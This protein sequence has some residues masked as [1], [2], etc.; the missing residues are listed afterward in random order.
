MRLLRKDGWL[1]CRSAA[2][3]GPV[4]ILAGKGG[5]VLLIQVKSGQR[6]INQREREELRRWAKAYNGRAEVWYF[7]GGGMEREVVA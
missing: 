4:D 1:C 5:Q 2:S 7:K 6:R 3:H